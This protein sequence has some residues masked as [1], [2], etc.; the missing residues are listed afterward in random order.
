MRA[1]RK[2]PWIGLLVLIVICLVA[3]GVGGAVTYREIQKWYRLEPIEEEQCPLPE[4]TT[5]NP[6]EGAMKYVELSTTDLKECLDTCIRNGLAPWEAF[7]K[8]AQQAMKDAKKLLRVSELLGSDKGEM[9]V[10]LRKQAG[11]IFLCVPEALAER[12]IAENLAR[13]SEYQ[14]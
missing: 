3:S 4:M 13:D 12:L 14:E 11:L 6:G 7:S 10:D 5:S 9:E 2:H 1:A 8:T